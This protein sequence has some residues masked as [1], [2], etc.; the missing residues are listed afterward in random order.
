METRPTGDEGPGSENQKSDGDRF[1][2]ESTDLSGTVLM[3]SIAS[4]R[5]IS[6]QLDGAPFKPDLPDVGPRCPRWCSAM[7]PLDLDY[8]AGRGGCPCPQARKAAES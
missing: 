2:T 5:R 7:S 4:R 1:N 6:R 8:W 3:R